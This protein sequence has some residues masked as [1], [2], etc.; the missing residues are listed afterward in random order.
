MAPTNLDAMT[1]Q[2]PPGWYADPYGTPG[3]QRWWD[4]AQWTQA[5]QPADEWDDAAP[6][7]PFGAP[8]M[9]A[10]G[11]GAAGMGTPGT[12]APGYGRQPWAAQQPQQQ[13]QWAPPQQKSNKGLI[14]GLAGGGGVIAVLVV[15]AILFAT[16]TL[17]GGSGSSPSPT[18]TSSTP[19]AGSGDSPV[20]GTINDTQTGLSYA[21]L[22]G[23]W[24]LERASVLSAGG[25]TQGEEAHVQEDYKD[26]RTSKVSAYYANVYSGLLNTKVTYTGDLEA[27]AKGEFNTLE[28]T[29]YPLHHTRQ[30]GDSKSYTVSGKKAWYFK[31][32]LKYPDAATYGW[33]F[34]SETVVV[35]AVDRGSGQRPAL[36]Y[37]SIPDS[38]EHQGDLDQSINSLK[39]Q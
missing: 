20:V 24:T 18:P 36:L 38:H 23:K 32:V 2:T 25:F 39:A 13:Q 15:V 10:A 26:D 5:T 28:P 37:V 17:G 6:S 34:H 29:N 19:L 8:G 35:I 1:G 14:W 30:D 31:T 12:E 4:G 16:G 22:G 27:A 9:G 33:N 21:Q 7:A 3:L 11:M